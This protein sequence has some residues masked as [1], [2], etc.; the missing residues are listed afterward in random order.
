MRGGALVSELPGARD[1]GGGE[2]DP[3]CAG[4]EGA[5]ELREKRMKY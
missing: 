4:S 3:G 1:A 5:V 2:A